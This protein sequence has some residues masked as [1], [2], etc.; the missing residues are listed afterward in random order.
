MQ[1][2]AIGSERGPTAALSLAAF[3]FAFPKRE[4]RVH[5]ARSV[6]EIAR[7]P[8]GAR[9]THAVFQHK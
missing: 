1:Q 8:D 6:Q 5:E 2:L 3:A 4:E 7:E 9:D